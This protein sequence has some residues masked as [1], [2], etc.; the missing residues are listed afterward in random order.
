M[1]L[2]A[3]EMLLAR[4]TGRT[5]IM[6][7]ESVFVPVDLLMAHDM[8]G[9]GMIRVF[10]KECGQGAVVWDP[11]RVVLMADHCVHTADVHA[12]NNVRLLREFALQQGICHFYD[13]GLDDECGTSD[14]AVP[15]T[16]G[17]QS[18]CHYGGI[19]HIVMAE[20]GLV[21][22][23]QILVGTDSHTCTAG[24][25]GAFAIGLGMTDAAFVLATGK[26]LIRV[27]QVLRVVL[28][29]L[30]PA[31]VTARDA[32]FFL[33]RTLGKAAAAGRAV[34]FTGDSVG[35]LSTA[36]RMV[37]TN[38]ATEAGV[39]SALFEAGGDSDRHVDLYAKANGPRSQRVPHRCRANRGAKYEAEYT[40]CLTSLEPRVVGPVSMQS[41]T[42]AMAFEHVRPDLVYIGGC[43]GGYLSDF[44]DAASILNGR[45][46]RIETIGVPGTAA[47]V[48]ELKTI[49]RGSRSVWDTLVAAGV[50]MSERVGCGACFGGF[51]DTVGRITRPLTCVSTLGRLS[52]GRY[53]H[54]GI[55]MYL[56]SAL[57]V[58]ASALEGCIVDPRNYL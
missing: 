51:A 57:T 2:T 13:S 47:I 19:S 41:C 46:V 37:I 39:K 27:P 49:R 45:E 43:S 12:Q 23:G 35:S 26:I 4:A 17:E 14:D 42:P 20:R 8:C 53:G 29:G 44:L 56:A 9:P 48:R 3:T 6:P 32:G 36:D 38:L 5:R 54:T 33:L 31:G 34:E 15:G 7:G 50:Q 18:A 28:D 22:S 52:P 40:L 24:A 25:F 58:A 10:Q 21:R 11:E 1:G 30:L 16:C 55:R